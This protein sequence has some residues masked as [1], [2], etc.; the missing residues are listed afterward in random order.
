MT[1]VTCLVTLNTKPLN[2]TKVAATQLT[3]KK[4]SSLFHFIFFHQKVIATLT[5]FSF[6]HPLF[7]KLQYDLIYF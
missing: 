1:L 5:N 6:E 7:A 4:A 2:L 3:S